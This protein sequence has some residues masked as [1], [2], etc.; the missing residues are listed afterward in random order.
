M[1]DK[2]LRESAK[3]LI[4]SRQQAA[5]EIGMDY[6]YFTRWLNGGSVGAAALQK[7]ENWIKENN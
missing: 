2:E 6:V 5:K 4:R 3:N 1:D 7:I